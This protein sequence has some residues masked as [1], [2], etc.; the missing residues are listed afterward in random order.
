MK[1]VRAV[2]LI[3]LILT[4]HVPVH[5]SEIIETIEPLLKAEEFEKARAKIDGY[6]AEDPKSVD[7]YMMLGNL[8]FYEYMSSVPQIELV[9]NTD[10]SVFVTGI[11]SIREATVTVPGEVGS[12]VAAY[13]EKAL[14]LD[15]TRGDIHRGMAYVLAMAM[16]KDE[17]FSQFRRMKKVLPDDGGLPY[18]MSGYAGML[19]ERGRADWSLE[20][21]REILALYPGHPGVLSGAAQI[22]FEEGQTAKAAAFVSKALSGTD[23][24]V[25]MLSEGILILLVSGDYSGGL[26]AARRIS[27]LRGDR[28][29]LVYRGL[30]KYAEG[31]QGWTKDLETF[32][33]TDATGQEEDLVAH[34]LS[35]GYTGSLA[36]FEKSDQAVE[37]VWARLL[38]YRAGIRHL[39]DEAV[40]Y[41]NYGIT[42]SA[43]K[44]YPE[45]LAA[46]ARAE[47]LYGT[48]KDDLKEAL[49]LFY[50][51]TLQ[52][53]GR[54][55]DADRRWNKLLEVDTFYTR[56]AASWFLGR[57]LYLSGKKGEALEMFLTISDRASESKYATY[58]KN[59]VNAI[60]AGRKPAFAKKEL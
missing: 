1:I 10:E 7:A 28:L 17:L 4:L 18:D 19:K 56:S 44:N 46:F 31:K 41:M 11:G 34:L 8:K 54:T 49:N 22:Y 12:E 47:E 30:M 50:A 58:A 53:S 25:N 14:T 15:I 29:Y 36:D 52:D 16:M 20:A 9:S 2:S 6:L 45:A 55:D 57:N 5:A 60:N 3:L 40:P 39:P 23:V 43:Y 35:E 51:W 32:M 24:N 59:A 38:L 48:L 26:S 42:M 27:E 37:S 33:K 21:Y 13:L